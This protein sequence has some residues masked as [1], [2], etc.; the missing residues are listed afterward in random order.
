MRRAVRE[1]VVEDQSKDREQ[2]DDDT[3]QNLVE[4][5]TV[6]LD[7]FHYTH[8]PLASHPLFSGIL[9]RQLT[10]DNDIQNQNNESDYTATCAISPAISMA[11]S[12]DRLRHRDSEE[13][14]LDEEVEESVGLHVC[15]G[16]WFVYCVEFLED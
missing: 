4:R 9:W 14:E 8:I 13:A 6:R 16:I 15:G 7:D 10:K 1:K 12:S 3:P 11:L 5:R 2:E